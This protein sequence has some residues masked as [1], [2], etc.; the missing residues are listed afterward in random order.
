M[1]SWVFSNT[2]WGVCGVFALLSLIITCHQI[3]QHL[4]HWTKPIYQKWIVRILFMVCLRRC[5]SLPSP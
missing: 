3:Y 2:T 1:S 4:F 5:L